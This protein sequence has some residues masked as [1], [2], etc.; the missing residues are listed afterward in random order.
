MCV[1]VF[2]FLFS[3]KDNCWMVAFVS[4]YAYLLLLMKIA[5]NLKKKK[6]SDAN[7]AGIDGCTS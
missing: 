1:Y 4:K 3:D 7:I 5:Y 6:K 2:F